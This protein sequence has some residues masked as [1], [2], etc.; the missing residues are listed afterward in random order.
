MKWDS[1]IPFVCCTNC[2]ESELQAEV[3]DGSAAA[4][5]PHVA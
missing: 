2:T 5:D 1:F 4:T 3:R